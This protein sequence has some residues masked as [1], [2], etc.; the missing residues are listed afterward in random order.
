MNA[1]SRDHQRNSGPIYCAE[2]KT[3]S[4]PYWPGWRAF[5]TDDPELGEPPALAFYCLACALV[6]FGPPRHRPLDQWPQSPSP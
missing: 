5:R 4:G 2:C 1:S 3:S 6:H